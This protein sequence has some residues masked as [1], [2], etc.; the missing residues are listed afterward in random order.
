MGKTVI[1]HLVDFKFQRPRAQLLRIVAMQ[2][3]SF[4]ALFGLEVVSSGNV[5]YSDI[6]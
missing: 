5:L 3:R 2:P 1:L 6:L 4:P